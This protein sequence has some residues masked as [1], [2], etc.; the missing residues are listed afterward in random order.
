MDEFKEP[1]LANISA[2]VRDGYSL[3]RRG[4]PRCPLMLGGWSIWRRLSKVGLYL[5]Q[6]VFKHGRLYVAL[7]MV[8]TR[9]GVKLLILDSDGK[10]TNKTTNVV[11]KE[12]FN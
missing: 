11:Y 6:P 5:R 12:M 4:S 3:R 9:D 10:P 7:S 8:K 2:L 1:V